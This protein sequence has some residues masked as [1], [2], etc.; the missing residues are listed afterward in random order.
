[1]TNTVALDDQRVMDLGRS[2]EFQLAAQ[3]FPHFLNHVYIM[4]P[5]PG[6]GR[7]RFEK[8]PHLMELAAAMEEHTWIAYLKAR[9]L[10]FSWLAAARAAWVMRFQPGS[11][12]LMLSRGENES[13]ALLS[14]AKFILK[15]L[16]PSWQLPFG[17]DSRRE[18]TYPDA[19]NASILALPATEDAGR[20]LTAS[21]VIQDEADFHE[22]DAA[23]VAA[24]EPSVN[25]GGQV[26][27]GSTINK[28]KAAS[29]FRET[30]V[31]SPTNGWHRLFAGWDARPGRDEEW[32]NRTKAS[33]PVLDLT[34]LTPDLFMEQEY[35]HTIDEALKPAR[36]SSAFDPDALED[37][38]MYT[39]NPVIT[40][41]PVKIFQKWVPGR[42]YMAATDPS[43]GVGGD[44]G[45]TVV[46][47]QAS[48]YVVASI[49]SKHLTASD[50]AWH[51]VEMLR[52]YQSP[53]W[54]IEDNGIGRAC[55]DTA[56]D[57]DYSNL[58][59]RSAGRSVKKTGWHTDTRSHYVLWDDLKEA[60]KARLITIPDADGLAQFTTMITDENGWTQAQR[61]AHDDYP[62]AV[63]IAWQMRKHASSGMNQVV[64]LRSRW[65]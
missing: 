17:T 53:I 27:R 31:G 45:V 16:P 44:F 41:G 4:E 54:G 7:I 61:G 2:A 24:I 34:G 52:L 40:R 30:F 23:S 63:A 1:M 64:V 42:R 29:V 50:L 43:A 57:L 49:M 32:Y 6:R 33:I 56:Q 11:L 58:Y 21:L 9:Q 20:G 15:E 5:P 65:G 47:D 51:S 36:A 18:L 8:W 60:F 3:S 55:I 25:A 26:I 37:L 46:L 13:N 10:G 22:Y 38:K 19:Q 35:P 14:K 48:G 12:S 39:R 28:R 62:T 59:R